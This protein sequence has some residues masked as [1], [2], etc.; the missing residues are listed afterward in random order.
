M[1]KENKGGKMTKKQWEKEIERCHPIIRCF[2][3]FRWP[4]VV[5][6]F[7]WLPLPILKGEK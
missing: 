6:H 7:G 5:K 4:E 1:S 3:K 2:P